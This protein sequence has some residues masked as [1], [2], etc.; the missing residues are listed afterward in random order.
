MAQISQIRTEI[1]SLKHS[2]FRMK[3]V[4]VTLL[5]TAFTLNGQSIEE[6]TETQSPKIFLTNNWKF[7]W[8]TLFI[9]D[10]NTQLPNQVVQLP[11]FWGNTIPDHGQA[12]YF[13]RLDLGKQKKQNALHIPFVRCA[14]HVFVNGQSAGKLGEVG[15]NGLNYR[16]Q[17][18]SLLVSLPDSGTVNLVIQVAN[19]ENTGAGLASRP[20]LGHPNMLHQTILVKKSIDMIFVGC[21]VSMCIYLITMFFLYRE[22][23]AFLYLSL[24]CLAVVFR[25]LTTESSS[26]LLP[27]LFP[28]SGWAIWKKIEFACVYSVVGLLPMYVGNMFRPESFKRIEYTF[29]GIATG[30]CLLVLFTNHS[31]FSRFLDVAHIGLLSGFGYAVVVIF[32]ALRHKNPDA[33]V[34]L[35]G[36]LSAFP[37]IFLEILKNSALQVPIK[38]THLTE[39]GVLTFLIFQVYVLANHYATIYRNLS[40]E[41][42]KRTSQLTQSN[43][44]A[45]KMLAILSHD[46]R[47]PLNSLKGIIH[48]FNLGLLSDEELKSSTQHIE[49]QSGKTIFLVENILMWAKS[50]LSGITL[51]LDKLNMN[52]LITT[53][54]DLYKTQ[55][56]LNDVT[57]EAN[58]MDN[59]FVIADSQVVSLILRNLISNAIKFSTKGSKIIIRTRESHGK[60][61][62]QVSNT[63]T[64]MSA[65][66][67]T[68]LFQN[69][70][71][72]TSKDSS[73]IG[74]KLC[75][76]YLLA[77]ETDFEIISNPKGETTLSIPLKLSNI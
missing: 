10:Q 49:A 75:R 35:I 29:V 45:N 13:T 26:L 51:T 53:H 44:V 58:L 9:P 43:A 64:G 25:S 2:G 34:I 3:L 6:S 24:I 48:L 73:G 36:F 56:N 46:I 11:H 20:T 55:A 74:L 12:T 33:L 70:N 69:T 31:V 39:M 27:A 28:E 47:G 8:D 30:L 63:G 65:E 14:A 62:L 61:L 60:M 18:S 1:V 54:I 50:Q 7:Y 16:S 66:Q 41:V 57:L 15:N 40:S 32:K 72:I 21:I 22:G 71:T 42:E 5:C 17:L 23:Y 19:Y 68:A 77:M 76:A 38:I 37:F 59:P 52:S 67:V 4:W